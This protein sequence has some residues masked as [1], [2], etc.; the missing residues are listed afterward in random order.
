MHFDLTYLLRSA[1]KYLFLAALLPLLF[2]C[3]VVE[4]DSVEDAVLLD[5]KQLTDEV[6][7]D[8]TLR[9][10]APGNVKGTSTKAVDEGP[11]QLTGTD[12]EN[13]INTITLFLVRLDGSGNEV[14]TATDFYTV[15]TGGGLTDNNDGTYTVS[16]SLFTNLGDKHI[17]L[18]ANMRS[19]QIAAFVNGTAYQ[20]E[21]TTQT[22]VLSDVMDIDGSGNGSNI[23]MFGAYNETGSSAS[24]STVTIASGTVDYDFTSNTAV[25]LERL[26]NKVLLTFTKRTDFTGITDTD[27]PLARTDEITFNDVFEGTYGTATY[28]GWSSLSDVQYVLNTTNKQVY[29]ERR[30]SSV[31]H[32]DANSALDNVNMYWNQDP[33][34]SLSS[35]VSYNAGTMELAKVSGYADHFI[36]YAPGDI[37]YDET[38]EV[39]FASALITAQPLAYD[40]GKLSIDGLVSASHQTAGLYCLEN[41]VG[42]D[43]G[44]GSAW[45]G[46]MID[47]IAGYVTT[48]VVVAIRYIPKTF[49]VASGSSMVETTF[50][51]R[52]EAESAL[53][54]WTDSE[55]SVTYPANTYWVNMQ[56]NKYY[57]SAAR[58]IAIANGEDETQFTEFSGGY[59]YFRTFIDPLQKTNG[60]LTYE[61]N[62]ASIWGMD[63]NCYHL[64]NVQSI[65]LPSTPNLTDYIR[66]NSYSTLTWNDRGSTSIEVTPQ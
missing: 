16:M 11:Y 44:D 64:L 33:N 30:P 34:L 3:V 62:T 41:T 20:S 14:R 6:N 7:V 28:H 22:D 2:S 21:A 8:I 53:A 17:Y 46:Y 25:S 10:K 24:P 63:R 19:S 47:D 23:L 61:G 48:H 31:T 29:L 39:P 4:R 52:A 37:S 32:A 54:A 27:T 36:N 43:Y 49:Y 35:Y 42:N 12:G 40:T 59:S 65:T 57:T 51:T 60:V 26:V 38:N 1:K 55:T 45:G 56:T 5:T 13:E 15:Y 66:V 58:K 50:A 9:F 18:G